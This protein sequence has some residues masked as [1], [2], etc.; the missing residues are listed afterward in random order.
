MYNSE[1]LPSLPLSF[2]TDTFKVIEEATTIYP[3]LTIPFKEKV[4]ILTR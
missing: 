3:S 1:L 2:Q 4:I